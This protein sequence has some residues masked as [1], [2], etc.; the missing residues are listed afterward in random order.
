MNHA[1]QYIREQLKCTLVDLEICYDA[2]KSDV[3][4][5]HAVGRVSV[6]IEILLEKLQDDYGQKD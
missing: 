2:L 4:A 3:N 5:A 6:R 1:A